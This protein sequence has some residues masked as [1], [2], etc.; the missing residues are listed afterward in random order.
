MI[1][2]HTCHKVWLH[3]TYI[4][5]CT[6]TRAH[7]CTH[8]RTHTHTHTH[9]HTQLTLPAFIKK[10]SRFSYS[11]GPCTFHC[12]NDIG[13]VKERGL[14]FSFVFSASFFCSFQILAYLSV[15]VLNRKTLLR[16]NILP[17]VQNISKS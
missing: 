16:A 4:H 10:C 7:T 2:L 9:T 1:K 17:N 8:V 11:L 3:E 12:L 15:E 14:N 13:V 6:H 5:A